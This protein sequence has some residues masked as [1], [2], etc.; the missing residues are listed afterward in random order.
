MRTIIALVASVLIMSSS[1]AF[2]AG[3]WQTPSGDGTLTIAANGVG[4][5]VTFIVKA[6]ANVKVSYEGDTT[7]GTYYAAGTYHTSG[8]KSYA[9]GSSD[10]RIFM[11]ENAVQ[12][13]AALP[14]DAASTMTWTGWTA[15][16]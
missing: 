8:S 14:P 15:I 3:S 5:N 6:S 9:S 7:A 4:A 11:K 10:S 2:A 1:V 12:S 16:K 13:S